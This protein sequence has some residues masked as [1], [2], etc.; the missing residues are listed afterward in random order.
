MTYKME[1]YF[2]NNTI[3]QQNISTLNNSINIRNE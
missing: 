2:T 3:T 1:K